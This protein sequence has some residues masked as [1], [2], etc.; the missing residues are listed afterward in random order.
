MSTWIFWKMR[1]RTSENKTEDARRNFSARILIVEEK[2]NLK[3]AAG[4][5]ICTV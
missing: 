4:N 5:E 3:G 2:G 1:F